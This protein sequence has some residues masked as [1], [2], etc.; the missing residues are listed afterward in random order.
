VPSTLTCRYCSKGPDTENFAAICI[1]ESTPSTAFDIASL[2]VNDTR[3]S[4]IPS[5][6]DA[7]SYNNVTLAPASGTSLATPETSTPHAPITKTLYPVKSSVTYCNTVISGQEPF[8]L[9]ALVM[10]IWLM[11]VD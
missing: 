6:L 8:H 5:S 1:T 4:R 11:Q 7:E 9:Q 10:P 3:I 2:S